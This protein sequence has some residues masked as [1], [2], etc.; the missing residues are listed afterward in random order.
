MVFQELVKGFGIE[1]TPKPL[2]SLY[3][4]GDGIEHNVYYPS[5]KES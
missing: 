1:Y 4:W 2:C 5:L 3:V